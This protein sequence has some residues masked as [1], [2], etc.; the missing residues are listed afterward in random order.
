MFWLTTKQN[1][2][3]I[4]VHF[5]VSKVANLLEIIPNLKCYLRRLATLEFAQQV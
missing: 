4:R 5:K 2:A 1:L 3:D